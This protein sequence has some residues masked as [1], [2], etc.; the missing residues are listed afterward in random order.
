MARIWKI[1]EDPEK[2]SPNPEPTVHE[3]LPGSNHRERGGTQGPGGTQDGERCRSWLEDRPVDLGGQNRGIADE[4]SRRQTTD[5]G[6][7]EHPKGGATQQKPPTL[8]ASSW[9]SSSEISE[10]TAESLSSGI[11][12]LISQQAQTVEAALWLIAAVSE[13]EGGT[14]EASPELTEEA[15][16]RWM[17]QQ[18]ERVE[19]LMERL[20]RKQREL[21]RL[22]EV[23]EEPPAK[24]QSYQEQPPAP[25]QSPITPARRT[26]EGGASQG[27][28]LPARGA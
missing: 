18:E 14:W 10:A 24:T 4:R 8:P 26:R 21:T 6:S 13:V 1:L 2:G 28:S 22:E 19:E 12:E 15:L 23:E 27:E 17:D 3:A 25:N 11:K 9:G 7:K 5:G 20:E 16:T